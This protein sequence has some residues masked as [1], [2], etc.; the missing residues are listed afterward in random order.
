MTI[1]DL[2]NRPIKEGDIVFVYMQRYERALVGENIYEVNQARPLPVADVPMARGRVEWDLD[3]ND[4]V[5][6]YGWTCDAWRGK[7]ASQMRGGNYA[8][9]LL[10]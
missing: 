2:H 3:F 5:V 4:F 8:Y 1:K 6:R 10:N 7:S 9:E